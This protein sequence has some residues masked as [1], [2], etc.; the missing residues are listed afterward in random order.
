MKFPDLM[1]KTE[2]QDELIHISLPM[3]FTSSQVPCL[4]QN[5]HPLLF[6]LLHLDYACFAQIMYSL[7]VSSDR[8]RYLPLQLLFYSQL[9]CRDL[10]GPKSLPLLDP[11]HPL[12]QRRAQVVIKAV[13]NIQIFIQIQIVKNSKY[14][15]CTFTYELLLH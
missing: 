7:A 12:K 13:F 5:L 3:S 8:V 15:L 2:Q 4:Q 9:N 10:Q 11:R 14:S 1:Q 6:R